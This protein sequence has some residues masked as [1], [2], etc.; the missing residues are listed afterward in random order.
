MPA[1]RF[2][3]DS[4]GAFNPP[5]ISSQINCCSPL[6]SRDV[7]GLKAPI[8]SGKN[9]TA[10]TYLSGR[11]A[12]AYLEC[13]GVGDMLPSLPI[14]LTPD[15]YVPAPLEA[16]YMQAWDKFPAALKEEMFEQN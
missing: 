11:E 2:F 10:G 13:F 12:T 9:R 8:E 16:T 4:I 14:F 1:V 7:G 6:G 5:S 15:D 3:P